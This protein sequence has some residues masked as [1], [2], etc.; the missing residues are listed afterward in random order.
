[1]LFKNWLRVVD[2]NHR[3]QDYESYA[4]PTELTR[5]TDKFWLNKGFSIACACLGI[6]DQTV[7]KLMTA[8]VDAVTIWLMLLTK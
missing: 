2:L 7:T 6:F 3:P 5:L 1:M 4:L 8:L